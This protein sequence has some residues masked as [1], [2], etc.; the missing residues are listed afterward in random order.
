MVYLDKKDKKGIT[1]YVQYALSVHK[2]QIEY[3]L[4]Q[5]GAYRLQYFVL[6]FG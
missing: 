2:G 5:K 6:D 1:I 3:T 4:A